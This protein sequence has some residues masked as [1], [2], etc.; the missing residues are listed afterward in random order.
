M[1]RIGA[2]VASASVVEGGEDEVVE[3]VRGGAHGA[4]ATSGAVVDLDHAV[5]VARAACLGSSAGI[6]GAVWTGFRA[7]FTSDPLFV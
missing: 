5:R 3:E 7:I 2:F 6:S 1:S 4:A